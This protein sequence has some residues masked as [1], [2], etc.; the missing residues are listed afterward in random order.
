[1]KRRGWR[2][3]VVEKI[4]YK[5]SKSDGSYPT[6]PSPLF[7]KYKTPG[8]FVIILCI[9]TSVDQ[10]SIT[11]D[12]SKTILVTEESSLTIRLHSQQTTP[13]NQTA[14]S[15]QPLMNAR[16]EMDY[17]QNNRSRKVPRMVSKLDPKSVQ[18]IAESNNAYHSGIKDGVPANHTEPTTEREVLNEISN[19]DISHPLED[20]QPSP[21][22][23]VKSSLEFPS[24]KSA[25]AIP[26]SRHQLHPSL[27]MTPQN[28]NTSKPKCPSAADGM[29]NSKKDGHLS[30]LKCMGSCSRIENEENIDPTSVAT[31]VSACIIDRV[32]SPQPR[33]SSQGLSCTKSS[34]LTISN[35]S[36]PSTWADKKNKTLPTQIS[37]RNKHE[38]PIMEIPFPSVSRPSVSPTAGSTSISCENPNAP[39][40]GSLS[41]IKSRESGRRDWW[42]RDPHPMFSPKYAAQRLL[43]EFPSAVNVNHAKPILESHF[44]KY[45]KIH[46][47]YHYDQNGDRCCKGF[48]VFIDPTSIQRV[49]TDPYSNICANALDPEAP[50]DMNITIR[51]SS[52]SDL[53]RTV[54]IRITGSR[55]EEEAF[56]RRYMYQL[57]CEREMEAKHMPNN[58]HD[59]LGIITH[60]MG[61]MVKSDGL[62]LFHKALLP[63][64]V[65]LDQVP[66]KGKTPGKY[67]STVCVRN[68]NTSWFDFVRQ[69]RERC[70]KDPTQIG[71][72]T[73]RG[74]NIS[75]RNFVPQLCDHLAEICSIR[76]PN[77]KCCG[78]LVSVSGSRDGRHMMHELQK[79]PGLFVRWA[80]ERDGLFDDAEPA[81][82]T[83]PL[84]CISSF[85]DRSS[86]TETDDARSLST[87]Q[88]NNHVFPTLLHPS[89]THPHLRRTLMHTYRGRPLIEDNSTGETKFLDES[90]IFVGRLN[91]RMETY[92]TL[93]K[94]FQKYGKI[95]NMEFNPKAVP[96]HVNN[97]TARIM[98]QGQESAAR[99]IARENGSISF[100]TAI[101]VELRRVIHSDVH[102]RRVYVDLTGR[103]VRPPT[104]SNLAREPVVKRVTESQSAIEARIQQPQFSPGLNMPSATYVP[105]LSQ[106]PGFL[107]PSVGIGMPVATFP[108]R[109]SLSPPAFSTGDGLQHLAMLGGQG[110]LSPTY[111]HIMPIAN[112]FWNVG[113]LSNGI[114][115]ADQFLYP[116]SEAFQNP[117]S[118][119]GQSSSMAYPPAGEAHFQ[120]PHDKQ[121]AEQ[122]HTIPMTAQYPVFPLDEPLS[123]TPG[124]SNYPELSAITPIGDEGISS[125]MKLKP[126]AYKEE[127]G[128]VK[129][130][131]DDDELKAY[132]VENNLPYPPQPGRTTKKASDEGFIVTQDWR[133]S[134]LP[135]QTGG[136]DS[137]LPSP[138]RRG[139]IAFVEAQGQSSL[140]KLRLL[141]SQSDYSLPTNRKPRTAIEGLT[142]RLVWPV[143]L[144]PLAA[145]RTHTLLHLGWRGGLF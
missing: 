128:T 3:Q 64:K 52:A 18:T 59:S 45:G 22:N 90:A 2:R 129:A 31:P 46:S 58:D 123:R 133:K 20:G 144:Q 135:V 76:P 141:R 57:L 107:Q 4:Q 40:T 29:P 102:T 120:S 67:Y 68:F 53:E 63:E 73:L 109:F 19:Q 105:M 75:E 44:S 93:Y 96:S 8:S 77:E 74:P 32:S 103:I 69:V 106:Q 110:S 10:P 116:L 35:V 113:Q 33:V 137:S 92:A 83:S 71:E 30:A 104:L 143:H 94:R 111:D 14:L 24:L 43:V 80:D 140:S 37:G 39:G 115:T 49:L 55:S 65:I 54:F 41:Q 122:P 98:Y 28:E 66:M 1:M 38:T 132:C 5:S 23:G 112:S 34:I 25:R 9:I 139:S 16:R 82:Q 15:I 130:I 89:A 101:K 134:L 100:G 61:G 131:Y 26:P 145:K 7:C 21:S 50:R 84:N 51:P 88:T 81:L 121:F 17:K 48:V 95:C 11:I 79:I 12:I 86:P 99:A 6:T 70:G 62:S 118:T 97:A 72:I 136:H 27:V 142:R 108:P 85:E 36:D 47:V 42:R 119:N 60:E 138:L 114:T 117:Q 56:E 127:N 91:K 78:W 125:N 87:P 124:V 126:V 13:S